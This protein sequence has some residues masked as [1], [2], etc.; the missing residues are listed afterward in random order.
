MTD[1]TTKVKADFLAELLP[2]VRKLRPVHLETAGVHPAGLRKIGARD[3]C[4]EENVKTSLS[5]IESAIDTGVLPANVGIAV[6]NRRGPARLYLRAVRLKG[7]A[8]PNGGS[9]DEALRVHPEGAEAHNGRGEILWDDGRIDE[10]LIGGVVLNVADRRIDSS[11]AKELN[12]LNKKLLDRASQEI[13][14]GRTYFED[15]T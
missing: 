1:T 10:A 12:K 11:V 5:D 7:W 8:G 2:A 6:G 3:Q 4:T 15:V 9:L 13:H 14:G